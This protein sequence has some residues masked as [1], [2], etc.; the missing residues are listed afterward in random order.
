MGS[1]KRDTQRINICTLPIN[2]LREARR[3]T[4][5]DHTLEH[6]WKTE[7]CRDICWCLLVSLDRVVQEKC[8]FEISNS[9]LKSLRNNLKDNLRK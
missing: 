2:H 8:E 5:V 7:E 6:L 1:G 9:Q 4:A 3:C